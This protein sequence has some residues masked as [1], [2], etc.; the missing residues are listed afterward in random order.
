MSP[1]RRRQ[2]KEKQIQPCF[3]HQPVPIE[4]GSHTISF[5]VLDI[6]S[7]PKLDIGETPNSSPMV[8]TWS[9]ILGAKTP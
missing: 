8:L 9:Y 5:N 7:D 2:R 4:E 1:Y 3:Y 6:G